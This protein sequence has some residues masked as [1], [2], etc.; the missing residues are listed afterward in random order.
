[1]SILIVNGR[2]ATLDQCEFEKFHGNSIFTTLRS[3]DK[4][5]CYFE[6]HWE[7]L[8]D[9]AKFFSYHLPD[10]YEIFSLFEEVLKDRSADQKI[11]IIIYQKSFAI[12]MEDLI[13]LS[14]QIYDGAT[15][16]ISK[17][18]I[19]PLLGKFKTGNSL[20]YFLAAAEAKEA[21]V[22]EGLLSDIYGHVVDG[23]R[24]GLMLL[25][26]DNL[27]G[28][29]GG[30]DSIMRKLAMDVANSMG[31]KTTFKKLT[32]AQLSGQLFLTNSLLGVIPVGNLNAPLAKEFF[33]RCASL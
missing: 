29:S 28:L 19:H 1:M 24:T 4:R 13:P 32:P 9:H 5:P 22:F 7:R 12:T 8:E 3:R 16:I 20:P 11:R 30:L 27:I 23:S 10:K 25:Q 6:L 15:V 14:P 21:S 33:T 2:K 26:E 18:V 17:Q 31:I